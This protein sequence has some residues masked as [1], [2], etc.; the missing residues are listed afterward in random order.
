MVSIVVPEIVVTVQ[1]EGCWPHLHRHIID[2]LS[3]QKEAAELS[4]VRNN[5]SHLWEDACLTS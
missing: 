5:K 1:G 2:C 4:K 3:N